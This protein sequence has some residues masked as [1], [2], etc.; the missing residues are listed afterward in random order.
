[1]LQ[2]AIT[3][4]FP[5]ETGEIDMAA[6][7][8]AM[9]NS[10]RNQGYTKNQKIFIVEGIFT[11]IMTV[12]TTASFLTGFLVSIG[13]SDYHIGLMS[14]S[15]TWSSIVALASIFLYQKMRRIKPFLVT[16]YVISKAL[17]C[18]IVIVPFF[19]YWY[20]NCEFSI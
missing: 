6:F 13:M 16:I 7:F 17:L 9:I 4:Y 10:V 20:I 3:G 1:M 5:S 19:C 15:A 12:F 11:N 8:R 2:A 18:F 14:T